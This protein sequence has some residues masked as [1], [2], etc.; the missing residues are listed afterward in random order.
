MEQ[1]IDETIRLDAKHEKTIFSKLGFA[2]FLL[3]LITTLLQ[4]GAAAVISAFWPEWAQSEWYIW[5]VSMLPLYLIAVPVCA[6]LLRRI[7][8]QSWEGTSLKLGEWMRI[9]IICIGVM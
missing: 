1:H 9:F 7:P 8:A 3:V 5:T 2:Y 6:M 4:L